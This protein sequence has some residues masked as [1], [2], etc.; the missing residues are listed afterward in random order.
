M[1]A[2]MSSDWASSTISLTIQIPRK[3]LLY[4]MFNFYPFIHTELSRYPGYFQE[5]HQLSI[6]LPEISR[7]NLTGMYI[8]S[9]TVQIKKYLLYTVTC[10]TLP[11]HTQLRTGTLC[12]KVSGLKLFFWHTLSKR[13]FNPIQMQQ[14]WL[15]LLHLNWVKISLALNSGIQMILE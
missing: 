8:F 13:N 4:T 14:K 6:W 12:F 3:Y 1:N 5:P 15:F 11:I 2:Y 9:S 10:L 7:V